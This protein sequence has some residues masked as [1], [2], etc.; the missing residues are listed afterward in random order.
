M[1]G[2]SWRTISQESNRR[3]SGVKR[4]AFGKP[5]KSAGFTSADLS[6]MWGINHVKHHMDEREIVADYLA[7]K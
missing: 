3:E 5:L 6:P 2:R 4:F 1:S 7:G